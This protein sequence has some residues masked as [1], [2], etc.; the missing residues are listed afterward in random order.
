MTWNAVKNVSLAV[1]FAFSIAACNGDDDD[2]GAAAGPPQGPS[3]TVKL[4]S[5]DG[6]Q[7]TP[8]VTTTDFGAG[9]LE[10]DATTGDISGFVVT[11]GLAGVTQAHVHLAARGTPGPIIVPLA[12]GP[13]LWVVPDNAAPLSPDQVTAFLQDQLY[14]N[15]HTGANP[16]GEIRG[17]L[18]KTGTARLASLDGAQ[19]VPPVTTAALGA[20]IL[21]VDAASGEVSG[22]VVSSGITGTQAHVHQAARGTPGD[23]IVPL[24]GGPTLWVVP[25]GAAA[26]DASQRSA[27]SSDS[28]YYN[29]HTAANPG[30]E[31]RGQLDKT[32]T[33]G[34]AALNGEQETPPV[35]TSGFG[36]GLVAVDGTTGE[37]SGFVVAGGVPT[38]NAAHV[39]AAPRGT[40][41]DIV[42]PMV[43]GGN[44][45]VIPDDAA[46]LG[47]AE[48]SAFGTKGLYYNVHTPAY[49]G[50]EIRGQLE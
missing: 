42:V 19:E 43:G 47:A 26:L 49:P 39:H 25:D 46:A 11:S 48:R 22:F 50:G 31:I 35:A 17:Q 8:A 32:G 23:V 12:G 33:L 3:R 40:P 5:L 4:A 15:V 18:D 10:V 36:A 37:V 21:A 6:A 7:E 34:F 20:G 24:A 44:F 29:V 30:G 14:F 28:L 1:C 13:D 2:G 38:G 27:F 9:V 45:W 16:D 41:G